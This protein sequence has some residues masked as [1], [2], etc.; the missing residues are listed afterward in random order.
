MRFVNFPAKNFWKKALLLPLV[1][2]PFVSAI[3]MRQ[4]LS[5]FGPVNLM[6]MK[7]NL[8][9]EPLNFLGTGMAGIFI[10]QLLHLYP[11]IYLNVLA[12]LE[13]IETACIESAEN[14]GASFFQTFR[15]VILP[16]AL[17]GYFAGAFLTFIWSL[18]DLGT[19]LVFDYPK[20]IPVIIFQ[21]L[22]DI[23]SNPAGYVLVIFVSLIAIAIFFFTRY[24]LA[25]ISFVGIVRYKTTMELKQLSKLVTTLINFC[26]GLLL[27]VSILPHL[28]VIINSFSERWFFTVIPDRWTL[29]YYQEIFYHPVAK[30]SLINSVVYSVITGFLIVIISVVSGFIISRSKIPGK[31]VI[32]GFIIFPMVMP[33][34]VF[35]FSYVVAFSESFIDPRKFPVFLLIVAYILRRLPFAVRSVVANFEQIDISCEE[36]ALNLG[37]SRFNTLV[38]VTVPMLKSGIISGF[39]FSF[40]F[41]MMEV[42]SSLILV[43]KQEYFPIAKGIYQ[44]AG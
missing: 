1:A 17:P 12:S 27:F 11:I 5:R 25:R 4:I 22:T 32:E 36:A 10:L 39:I 33:G 3:G 44:L 37:S 42:S 13:N 20:L 38:K 43:T 14:L 21:S 40:A 24:L 7:F 34:I 8:L 41:S 31:N 19:P 28:S 2:P 15:K 9:Q 29:R 16:L 30:L 23:N 26:L 35:A 6:L 18:T